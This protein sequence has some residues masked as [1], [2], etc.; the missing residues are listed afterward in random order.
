MQPSVAVTDLDL[1]SP[2]RGTYLPLP[3]HHSYNGLDGETSPHD[4]IVATTFEEKEA[5]FKLRYRVLV[6][7]LH[8]QSPDQQPT[9][10]ELDAFDV[11][12]THALLVHRGSGRVS[13]TTRL[14]LPD[15]GAL[16]R[17]FPLQTLCDDPILRA[18][19]ALPLDRTAE[20]SRFIIAPESR[21][22]RTIDADA[23]RQRHMG[24]VRAYSLTVGL[25]KAVV[26]MGT[27]NKVEH[28]IAIMTPSLLRMLSR[29]GIHF[30]II[31]RPI[32]YNGLRQPCHISMR[33]VMEGPFEERRDVWEAIT[34]HGA[35]W[36]AFLEYAP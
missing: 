11:R 26:R 35:Y 21:G 30:H 20:V 10:R 34:A 5:A 31:G 12:A 25:I 6:E 4:M 33:E 18:A 32:E 16:D 9:G 13:G 15:P 28:L 8:H 19:G 2:P 24:L 3:D 14:V 27:E 17:S 23:R 36:D 1:F 22:A 7:E 29:L